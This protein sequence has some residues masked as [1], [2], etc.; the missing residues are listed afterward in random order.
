MGLS[1]SPIKL[2]IGNGNSFAHKTATLNIDR[3]WKGGDKAELLGAI[4]HELNHFFQDKEL[5][6]NHVKNER[7]HIEMDRDL[8]VW[9]LDQNEFFENHDSY[10]G[11]KADNYLENLRNYIQPEQNFSAYK[12]QFVEVECMRRGDIVRDEFK[13]LIRNP[14]ENQRI[15]NSAEKFDLDKNALFA[16]EKQ[17]LHL[18]DL[19][20]KALS[21][22]MKII[23]NQKNR[24]SFPQCQNIYNAYKND[25][26]DIY[27]IIADH[28]KEPRFANA[29]IEQFKYWFVKEYRIVE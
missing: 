3:N 28:L 20:L 27:G 1:D 8:E 21:E 6:V 13:N 12:N 19:E 23:K 25:P 10:H 24:D 15:S 11:K 14:I 4:A 7:P 5:I 17:N 18:D 9:I 26:V 2:K 22:I 29:S 16:L